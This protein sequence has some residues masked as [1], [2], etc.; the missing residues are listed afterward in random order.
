MLNLA[1]MSGPNKLKIVRAAPVT[2]SM[3]EVI[4]PALGT[5]NSWMRA[6]AAPD[7]VVI[8]VE[9]ITCVFFDIILFSLILNSQKVVEL[10][11][12]QSGLPV[13]VSDIGVVVKV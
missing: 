1:A 10:F 2:M 11:Y 4:I 7:T 5:L 13:A 8:I 3:A 9:T 12:R 6:T